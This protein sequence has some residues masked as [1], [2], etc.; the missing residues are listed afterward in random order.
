MRKYNQQSIDLEVRSPGYATCVDN[1]VEK[2]TSSANIEELE[3]METLV[4]GGGGLG[5]EELSYVET[6]VDPYSPMKQSAKRPGAAWVEC[7]NRYPA[8]LLMNALHEVCHL[9]EQ[10]DRKKPINER[11]A[12]L[13]AGDRFLRVAQKYDEC[14]ILISN[15]MNQGLTNSTE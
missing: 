3:A 5:S 14:R 7:G 15:Q 2:R 4:A 11:Q 9:K 1:E 8:E 12:A 10:C 13:C 6:L